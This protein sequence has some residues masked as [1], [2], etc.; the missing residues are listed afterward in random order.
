MGRQFKALIGVG[1]VTLALVSAS[2]AWAAVA[3]APV[4]VLGGR[5]SQ[6]LP[7]ATPGGGV[8]SWTLIRSGQV[9]AFLRSAGGPKIQLNRR[10]LGWNGNISG[11][12]AIYQQ[13]VRNQSNIYIYDTGTQTRHQPPGVNTAGWEF[14]PRIDANNVLF[15]R[16]GRNHSWRVLLADTSGLTTT[17]LEKHTGRPVRQLTP[18]GVAGDW[19]TWARYAPRTHHGTVVLYQISTQLASVLAVPRGK[20]QYASTVDHAGDLFYVR[21]GAGTCGRGVTIREA[22]SGGG[23]D[24]PLARIPRGYD[25]GVMNVVDEG[26]GDG[27]TIYFDRVNCSSGFYDSYKVAVN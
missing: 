16:S 1:A 23:G 12:E 19:A 13:V 17:L 14:Y 22:I 2:L 15:G 6:M 10:G 25:I 3:A 24:V 5:G 4:K 21:S 9:D 8:L 26:P 7:A 20:V 27:V 11:T 18:G